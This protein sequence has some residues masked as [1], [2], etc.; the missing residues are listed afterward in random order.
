MLERLYVRHFALI[1]EMTVTF[2]SGLTVLSGETGAGKSIV[3]DAVSLLLGGR[4]D[5]EM[6]RRGEKSAYIEGEFNIR[7][8]KEAIAYL[9]EQSILDSQETDDSI[10]I[11]REVFSSGKTVCRI[12]GSMVNVG[13]LKSL[14]TFLMEIV[15]Q[16]ENQSLMDENKHLAF[17][18]ALGDEE[19]TQTLEE[20]ALL[21]HTA[22]ESK[23][24]LAS[25][26]RENEFR[27]ERI[28]R[29]T[30]QCEEIEKANLIEGE[31][32]ELKN[33]REILRNI[34]KIQ[35]HLLAAQNLLSG[36][37]DLLGYI[38]QAQDSLENIQEFDSDYHELFER[39]SSLYYEAEDICF[40]IEKAAQDLRFDNGN[41]EEIEE[42]LDLIKKIQRKYGTSIFEVLENYRQMKSQLEGYRNI[43]EEIDELSFQ[44][45]KNL[46]CYHQKAKALTALRLKLSKLVENAID[47]ELKDLNMPAAHFKVELTTDTKAFKASGHEEVR[48]LIRANI[49]EE[50]KPISKTASGGELSRIM[51]AVKSV[52]AERS[53]LPTIVFDEI[54][55]GISGK[56]AQVVAEKIWQI[57]RFR[58]AICVTHLQQIAAMASSQLLITKHESDGRTQ[59]SASY[60][61]ELGREKEIARL[62]GQSVGES[63][64]VHARSLLDDA[65]KYHRLYPV[66]FD[67]C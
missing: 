33:Q 16:H 39:V 38:K 63:A 57:A 48:F 6:V 29:L 8:T 60:L 41:L 12:N 17:F 19:Y 52:S 45:Q 66:Q 49:G 10:V 3:V 61:D 20:V 34:D 22:N 56:A 18:D 24:K 31:E 1:E 7:Q 46:D 2:S 5:K 42:R 53:S 59:T 62:L 27:V 15:G 36:D 4:S 54:D 32:E 26:C 25:L 9:V 55:A 13:T 40:S 21:Y 47:Q 28:E 50:Y 44:N 65:N 23:K 43:E 37:N 67:G 51:L 11:S 58:Q 30:K 14:A 35:R 64:R